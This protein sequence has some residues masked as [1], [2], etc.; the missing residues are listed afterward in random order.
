MTEQITLNIT[1]N[2][3]TYFDSDKGGARANQ[4][5]TGPNLGGLSTVLQ[6]RPALH[7]Q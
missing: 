4:I 6:A 7:L 3:F 5:G 2:I 1:E